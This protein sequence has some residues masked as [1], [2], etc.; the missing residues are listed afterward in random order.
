[1]NALEN[2]LAHV[3]TLDELA[4]RDTPL[5]RVDARAK[6]VVTFAF[7]VTLAS[8]DPHDLSRPWT[9]V[10]LLALGVAWGEVPLSML[11]M[12]VAIASPFALLIGLWNPLFDSRPE[13]SLGPLVL[14]AGT[15]SLL[16]IV[17]RFVLS[18][19]AVLLLVATTG[20]D[21]VCSALG[22]LGVPRVLVTQL[23]LLYRYAFVLGDE[24]VR[25]LRAHALRAP[26]HPRPSWR[27]ARAL[28]G[29]LLIRSL[30]RA[31]RVYAAMLCRG[32]T[33]ELWPLGARRLRPGD[34]GFLLG[35]CGFL[36]LARALDVPRWLAGLVL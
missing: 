15:L 10:V 26:N 13:C 5:A 16:S 14:S 20:F 34:W 35:G 27:T 18:L 21:R 17:L 31:E 30:G 4:R 3:H 24:V 36:V 33:G 29:Q 23:W 19:T 1:V 22:R 2:I 8:F 7:L 12:R 11:A 25:V 6:V 32:Y 9:L 28:F